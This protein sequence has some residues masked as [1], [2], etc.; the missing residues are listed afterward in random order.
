MH[1]AC[2]FILE[3][4]LVVSKTRESNYLGAYFSLKGGEI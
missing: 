1:L 2:Y 3:K 4:L